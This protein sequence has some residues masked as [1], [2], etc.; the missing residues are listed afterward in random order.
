[1]DQTDHF[2]DVFVY[3]NVVY[4]YFNVVAAFS[5]QFGWNKVKYA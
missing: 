2:A 3:E 4:G 1:M 5:V